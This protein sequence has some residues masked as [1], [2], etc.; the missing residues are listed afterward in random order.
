MINKIYKIINN[1]FSGFFKFI[2]FLRYLVAIF[3]VA[4]LLFLLIP[5]FFDYK[6]KEE[7]LKN[8]LYQHYN[9]K[10]EKIENIQYKSFP[11][12]HLLLSNSAANFHLESTA[13]RV[14][15]LF[16]YPKLFSI[17]NN[18]NFQARK[19]KLENSEFDLDIKNII[20]L[21]RFLLN[22]DK[23][24]FLRNLRIN[25]K[26]KNK[27]IFN[28]E[29]VN[30][31]NF[32]YKKNNIDGLIFNNKFYM[33]L[34]TELNKISFKIPDTG[35][36]TILN[37]IKNNDNSLL[38]GSL[39][40]KILKSNFKLNFIF[41]QQKIK[42]NNFFFRDKKISFNS[43]GYFDLRPYF[44]M[45]LDTEIHDINLDFLQNFNLNMILSHKNLIK[46]INFDNKIIFK[47]KKISRKM[48]NQLNLQTNLAFGRLNIIKTSFINDSNFF[49]NKEINLLAE[50]PIIYFD[51]LVKSPD[52][53]K[54]FKKLKINLKTKNDPIRIS[55]KG[56][57]NILNNKINFDQVE[58][59]GNEVTHENLEFIKTSF[60]NILFDE[61]FNK[62]FNLSKIRKFIY[63]IN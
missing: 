38:K 46:K 11:I 54:L 47:P 32:G 25:I 63:E 62:I 60:E 15:K 10:V 3:F 19:I 33:N 36:S 21:S 56:S 24:I 58:I 34:G 17:Y 16:I 12:P 53:K 35:I 51:C 22:L 42:I 1:K 26:D 14:K 48:I 59:D 20:P 18:K 9:L 55:V 29:K 61:E 31:V 44:K 40:G 45:K 28:F 7:I 2:F 49:C 52:K 57:L 37:I 4:I 23:D 50:Y 6:K 27:T 8:Y 41:N 43:D 13:I 30:F 5:E 39:Q